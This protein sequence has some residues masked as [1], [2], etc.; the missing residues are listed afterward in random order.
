LQELGNKGSAQIRTLRM[1]K[2]VPTSVFAN[3]NMPPVS[4]L[5]GW[6]LI[7]LKPEEGMI[8][9]GFEGREEFC[10]PSGSIQ[11]GILSAMLDDTMGPAAFIMSGGKRYT[12]TITMT[13]NFISPG[14][15]GAFECEAKVV[16]MGK[17]VVFVEARLMD[18]TGTLVATATSTSRLVETSKAIK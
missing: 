11:G 14:K 6:R 9:I 8:R 17:T 3:L 15:V 16:Q 4:K 18:D 1:T 10:N 5:L 2:P 7:D 12:P 13:V